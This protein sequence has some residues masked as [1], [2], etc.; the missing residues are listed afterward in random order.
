EVLHPGAHREALAEERG[1]EAE[2]GGGVV[3]AGGE[4]DAGELGEPQQGVGEEVDDG[5]GRD[6]A[7]V[8]VAGDEDGV[9]ALPADHL[10]EVVEEGSLVLDEVD[11][12]Q[13]APQ[14]P[15]RGVQDAH[16]PTVT[17]A[18]DIAVEPPRGGASRAAGAGSAAPSGRA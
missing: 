7:G 6:R 8:H 5:D 9:D 17:A 12:V 3:V 13:G 2:A 11:P 14:V 15:V 18:T 10:D 4:D 1:G 16:G